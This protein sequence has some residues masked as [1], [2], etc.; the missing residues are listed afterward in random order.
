M[1]TVP[2]LGTIA[3]VDAWH[4]GALG[5]VQPQTNDVA[6]LGSETRWILMLTAGFVLHGPG[7]FD[8]RAY[9]MP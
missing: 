7:E 4:D 5:K 8:V 3:R 2:P 6:G 9:V 1:W